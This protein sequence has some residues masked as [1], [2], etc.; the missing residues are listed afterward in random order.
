M[1]SVNKRCD[2]TLSLDIGNRVKSQRGL[3]RGLW[4]VNFDDAAAWQTANPQG[5]VQSDGAGGNNG[6]GRT[7]VRTQSHDRA[8]TELSIYLRE[9]CF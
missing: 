5:D 6:D 8:L 4:T 9:G 2:S 1:L 3:T 7:F